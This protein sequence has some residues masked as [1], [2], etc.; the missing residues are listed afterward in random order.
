MNLFNFS[1]IEEKLNFIKFNHPIFYQRTRQFILFNKYADKVIEKK[2]GKDS[3]DTIINL[4]HF[5]TII[6][7]DLSIHTYVDPFLFRL[8]TQY[9]NYYS[10]YI[11]AIEELT[12]SYSRNYI[13]HLLDFLEKNE[14]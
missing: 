4:N 1:S 5:N 3:F 2:W 8:A 9:K 7:E 6:W 13:L 12:S 11:S 14:L 10:M